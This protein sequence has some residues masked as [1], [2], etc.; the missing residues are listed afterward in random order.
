MPAKAKRKRDL[1]S[2]FQSI[3]RYHQRRSVLVLHGVVSVAF[4]MMMWFNWYASY[5]RYGTGFENNYFAD[6]IIVSAALMLVLAG[7]FVLMY[8]SE[9]RDRMVVL[10]LQQHADEVEQYEGDDADD[11]D[12]DDDSADY[13]MMNNQHRSRLVK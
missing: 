11:F 4:Q 3:E 1:M 7:H 2:T 12:D 10:A 8:L 6:R 9:S 5:A 13:T